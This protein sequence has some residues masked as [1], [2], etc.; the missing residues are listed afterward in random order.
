MYS[1]VSSLSLCF[2]L[3]GSG[4]RSPR[5]SGVA[6]RFVGT[7]NEQINTQR[8]CCIMEISKSTA[9]ARNGRLPAAPGIL[10]ADLALAGLLATG[11][12]LR[13]GSG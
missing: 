12:V 13:A 7:M 9:N 1:R 3:V 8:E 6:R 10:I 11:S 4:Y 2:L 5:G